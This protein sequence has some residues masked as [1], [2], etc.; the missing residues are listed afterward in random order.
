MVGFGFMDNLVMIQAGDY[1]DSTIGVMFAMS[2]LTAAAYGQVVSDVS[3]VM[4]GGAVEALAAR[5]NLPRA[6]LTLEQHQLRA[7]K[8]AGTSGA[9]VGVVIG[10]L[11]GMTCLLGMDLEKS[12]RLK[13][14]AE[15]RTL[16]DTLMEE[17]HTV[18]GAQHC[19]LF[20]LDGDPETGTLTSMGWKGR[21]PTEEE[22]R[23]T[24][25]NYD[26]DESGTVD[27]VQVYHALRQLNWTAE[28]ALV[29]QVIAETLGVPPDSQLN[30]DQFCTLMTTAILADEV[31][32]RIRKGGSRHWVLTTGQTLNV[33]NVAADP[34]ISDESRRKYTL[35]GYDVMSLL[36]APVI[37]NDGKVLGL[38][39]LVNKDIGAAEG[40]SAAG[41]DAAGSGS[42][43]RRRN[44]A[45]GFSA[46]DE[47]LLKML[48]SHCAIFLRHLDT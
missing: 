14:Q 47:R 2:T 18:I 41:D 46:D 32:L 27:A 16:Y 8:I 7:V 1:I 24:F 43:L 9:V 3:G 31:R 48:C 39:E 42:K 44:S 40:Y 10:C 5:L 35:R 26:T 34:R 37:D 29:E 6:N 30:F 4:S 20:L 28:L 15:L 33:R 45:Y 38:I 22:L 13:K 25:N 12:E 19:A 11:L 23:R 17:G 21:T 36:L